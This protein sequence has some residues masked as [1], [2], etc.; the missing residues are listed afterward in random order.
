MVN[1]FILAFDKQTLNHV[2]SKVFRSY[3]ATLSTKMELNKVQSNPS[4]LI[5]TEIMLLLVLLAT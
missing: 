2:H 1:G 5:E 3:V 4:D